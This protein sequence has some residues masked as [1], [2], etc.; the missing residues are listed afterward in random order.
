MSRSPSPVY[1]R[2]VSNYISRVRENEYENIWE[3]IN[4]K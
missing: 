4:I 3:N 1:S 2:P